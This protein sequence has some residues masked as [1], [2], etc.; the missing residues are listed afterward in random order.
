MES[1]NKSTRKSKISAIIARQ[2]VTDVD[3]KRE[4]AGSNERKTREGD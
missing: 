3:F 1:D 4:G 2:N